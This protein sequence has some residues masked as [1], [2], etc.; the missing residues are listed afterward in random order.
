MVAS[1]T[2]TPV[3][4]SHNSQWR[5][6]VAVSFSRSCSCRASLCS[7]VAAMRRLRPVECL[8]ERSLPSLLPFNQRLRVA[9]EMPKVST[10]SPLGSPR[11][12]AASVLSLRSFE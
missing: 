11:S 1:E 10:T 4:C 6:R 3:L 2:A 8:G 7:G 12:R 9:R 5:L